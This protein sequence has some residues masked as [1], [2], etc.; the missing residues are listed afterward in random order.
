MLR[1]VATA[2]LLL[3]MMVVGAVAVVDALQ[4]YTRRN[5]PVTDM[6][7]CTSRQCIMW[8]TCR[9]AKMSRDRNTSRTR[10][11]W[12]LWQP[13]RAMFCEG[14]IEPLPRSDTNHG[15]DNQK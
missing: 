2:T 11:S 13:E 4:R 7:L 3:T 6:T 1:D 5:D 8:D 10:Q 12:S 15:N 14:F 9:R